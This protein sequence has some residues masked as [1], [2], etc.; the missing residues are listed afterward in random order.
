MQDVGLISGGLAG[1]S[2]RLSWD[3]VTRRG[4][5]V[6]VL[7]GGCRQ[8]LDCVMMAYL[9]QGAG[10]ASYGVEGFHQRCEP[11]YND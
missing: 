4:K 7:L 8:C 5:E 3:M 1:F 11:G 6:G 2:Q 9:I 10:L